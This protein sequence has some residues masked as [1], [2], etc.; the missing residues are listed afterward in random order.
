MGDLHEDAGPVTRARVGPDRA[1]VFEV[2]QYC[3]L[4]LR[5]VRVFSL[6]SIVCPPL[7]FQSDRANKK[8]ANH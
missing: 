3:Q 1:A 8:A 6:A 5:T 4:S 7:D 2:P